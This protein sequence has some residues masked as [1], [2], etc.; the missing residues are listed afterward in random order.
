MFY[1]YFKTAFRNLLR[2]KGYAAINIVGLAVGVAAYL[3]IFL[4][5]Q[6][7][8][9]FDNFHTKKNEIYLLG[10]ELHSQDG[11]SYTDGSAFPVGPQIR[12]D[13]PQKL[14]MP[15]QKTEISFYV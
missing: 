3:L 1:N 11:L 14:F 10:T 8:T 7:E 9:S 15:H 6:F 12:I 2:N 4:V 13:F 5:I